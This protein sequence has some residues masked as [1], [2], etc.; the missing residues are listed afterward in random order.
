MFANA[1]PEGGRIDATFGP[2]EDGALWIILVISLLALVVAYG[3][4][5]G[6][7]AAPSGLTCGG[8]GF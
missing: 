8:R 3:L 6:V 4:R 1:A 5:R 2:F 7:L